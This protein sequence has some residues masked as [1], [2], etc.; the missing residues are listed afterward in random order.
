MGMESA[1]IDAAYAAPLR[2]E[3]QET[4]LDEDCVAGYRLMALRLTGEG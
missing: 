3:Y 2:V 4:V 1:L